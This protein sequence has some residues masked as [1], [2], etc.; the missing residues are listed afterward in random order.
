MPSEKNLVVALAGNPNAGK[1]TIFNALT[2]LHQHTGNWPGKTVEKR[3]GHCSFMGQGM[4]IVDLPGS[5][6][7]SARSPDEMVAR[8]FLT[9][10]GPDVVVCV[11]DA[12]NL[13]RNLYLAVQ[14]LETGLPTVIALNLVD[15][16]NSRRIKIDTEIL[17]QFLSGAPV[18]PT[19]ASRNRGIDSLLHAITSTGRGPACKCGCDSGDGFTVDY[20]EEIERSLEEISKHLPPAEGHPGRLCNRWNAL[21]L[22][23]GDHAALAPELSENGKMAVDAAGSEGERLLH[24]IGERPDILTADLRYSF[25]NGAVARSV[26]RSEEDKPTFSDRVDS[27]VTSRYLGLPIFAALMY[28]VFRLVIDVSAP[29]LSWV[30]WLMAAPLSAGTTSLL[31]MLSAPAWIHSLFTEGIIAGV[32]GMLVFVPGLIVLFLFLAFLEDSGYLARAAFI[33]DRMMRVIGLPGKSVIPL[34]LGFGCAV[35]AVYATRTMSSP[36][37][38]LLTALLIPF[39]SC[40]ARL[41]VYLVFSMAFFGASAGTFIWLIYLLGVLVAILFGVLISKTLLRNSGDSSFLLELPSYR[42]PTIKGM[43][44]QVW[45]RVRAFLK[46]AGTLILLVSVIMWF[47]LNT[48]WNVSEQRDSLFGM[49]SRL[50][51]PALQPAGFGDWQ[52]AGA[53]ATGFVAKEMVVSAMSQLYTGIDVENSSDVSLSAGEYLK[54]GLSRFGEASLQAGRSLLSIIPGV[55]VIKPST[56]DDTDVTLIRA[57]RERY[58]KLSAIAFLVFVL[59]YTPCVATLG[60]IRSEF[61]WRWA[62]TSAVS[63][64]GIAWLVTVAVFQTGRLLG[65]G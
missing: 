4:E 3:S 22:L 54:E 39:M 10:G 62:A 63:Q 24:L 34:V 35:P 27:V 1:S 21:K 36:R 57:L 44:I 18:I 19:V 16:A 65:F 9:Q 40:S 8:D 33:M 30:E 37:D 56:D 64:T 50:I 52:S 51:A 5:Y 31:N 49:A 13:E 58:S 17:S 46:E 38:R 20:G 11:L 32:G 43:A 15:Q 59:L 47:L 29:F 48:P 60:A 25:V 23:E 55:N 61:G 26:T 6:S 14:I 7:L 41:P 53:L 2:G 42:V 28:V 12:T 45:E